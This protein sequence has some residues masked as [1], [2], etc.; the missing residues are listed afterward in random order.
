[1][2]AVIKSGGKQ[3]RVAEGDVLE[4]ERLDAARG[5][6]IELEAALLF[7]GADLVRSGGTVRAVVLGDRKGKK[8]TVFK[9]KPKTGYR[10]KRGHRQI[11]TRIEIVSVAAS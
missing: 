2:Q 10:R 7:D 11:H 6:E 1:M 3:Y 5:D 8:V 9:Y 4:V